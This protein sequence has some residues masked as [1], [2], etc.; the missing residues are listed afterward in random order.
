MLHYRGDLPGDE[1]FR[2]VADF[3]GLRIGRAVRVVVKFSITDV[4][5]VTRQLRSC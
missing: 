1:V 2:Y 4:W 5:S 3:I